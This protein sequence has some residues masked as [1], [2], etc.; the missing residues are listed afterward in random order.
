[1][2]SSKH[3]KVENVVFAIRIRNSR[4]RNILFVSFVIIYYHDFMEHGTRDAPGVTI[5]YYFT[6]PYAICTSAYPLLYPP[7]GGNKRLRGVLQY[8]KREY[9]RERYHHAQQPRTR[10]Y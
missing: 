7:I 3:L 8:D 2:E 9:Y 4:F 5:L 10:C 6:V 1:M